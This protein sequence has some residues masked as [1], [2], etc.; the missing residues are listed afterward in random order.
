ML[1]AQAV[2]LGLSIGAL[3]CG[4]DLAL[5]SAERIGRALR[6][7]PLA[8]GLVIV[9]FGTSLPELFVSQSAAWDGRFPIAVGNVLGSNVANTFLVM[10]TAGLL[11]DIPLR[12]AAVRRLLLLHLGVSAALVLAMAQEEFAWPS[13]LLLGAL[14]AVC[15]RA[16][17]RGAGGPPGRGPDGGGG[18]AAGPWDAF[19]LLFGFGLL[20]AGGE[21]LVHSA[22][23]LSRLL[24]VP[25][26]L[27]SAVLVAFGTSCPELVTCLVAVKNRKDTGL[28]V[29]NLI[30]SNVFNASLVLASL[31]PWRFPLEDGYAACALVLLVAAALLPALRALGRPFGRREGALFL[32]A[33]AL[34][35]LW[36]AR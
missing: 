15:V 1:F 34:T 20:L 36:W 18:R 7:P 11:A 16:N 12:G 2:L 32:A 35:V 30:G 4:A 19:F 23:G 6:L 13:G 14:F 22:V 21:L 5:E 31:A 9:G 28:I 33:Y 24:G 27:V 10:G 3:Y 25:E 8:T 26:F 17:L 29:G